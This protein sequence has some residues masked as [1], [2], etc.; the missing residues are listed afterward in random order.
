[1]LSAIPM[2]D[3]TMADD[4]WRINQ[5]FINKLETTVYDSTYTM[6]NIALVYAD[7][8]SGR[9]DHALNIVRT[10]LNG[11]KMKKLGYYKA[12]YLML[13]IYLLKKLG[14]EHELNDAVLQF[15]EYTAK[16]KPLYENERMELRAGVEKAMRGELPIEGITDGFNVI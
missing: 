16:W 7:C 3:T 6:L 5:G 1:M 8:A 15:N 9:Y 12:E 4:I 11:R 13:K 2:G 10:V 14:R